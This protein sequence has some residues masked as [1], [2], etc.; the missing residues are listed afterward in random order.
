MPLNI[1]LGKTHRHEIEEAI[2]AIISPTRSK[3]CIVLSLVPGLCS[4]ENSM[5]VEHRKEEVLGYSDAKDAGL[6]C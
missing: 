1:A 2:V 4:C 5:R 6:E 3:M